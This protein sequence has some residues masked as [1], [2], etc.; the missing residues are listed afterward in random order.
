LLTLRRGGRP[1]ELGLSAAPPP[2]ADLE[3]ARPAPR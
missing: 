1:R 2:P 3:I